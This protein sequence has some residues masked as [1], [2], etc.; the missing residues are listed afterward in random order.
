MLIAREAKKSGEDRNYLSYDLTKE[1]PV[2]AG[3]SGVRVAG[4]CLGL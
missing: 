3:I 1:N 2:A 4:I